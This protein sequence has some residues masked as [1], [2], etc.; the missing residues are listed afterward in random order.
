MNKKF[1]GILL[2]LIAVLNLI[3]YALG[4]IGELLFWGT[5]IITAILAFLVLPK[6]K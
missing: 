2:I 3:F 4:R 5:V 1:L 6:L